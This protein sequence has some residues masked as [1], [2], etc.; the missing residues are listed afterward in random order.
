MK[1][2]K[3]LY[4]EEWAEEQEKGYIFHICD[5]QPMIDELGNVLIQIDD[6]DY[7]GDSRI[8]YEKDGKYG[9]LIFGWGSC[10]GCDALQSCETM[11]DVQ[12]IFDSLVHNV[13]W[14]NSLEELKKYF[15]E[16]DWPLDYSWH[17]DEGKLFVQ[18]VLDFKL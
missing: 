10:S 4:P 12:N 9:F 1:T 13:K 8:L 14:F 6:N 3:E 11:Q 15:K 16:K 2:A 17:L 7:S 18:Q 5:Y